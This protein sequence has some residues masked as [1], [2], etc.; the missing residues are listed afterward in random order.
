VS[1]AQTMGGSKTWWSAAVAAL[2]LLA[3]STPFAPTSTAQPSVDCTSEVWEIGSADDVAA[4]IA[5]WDAASVPGSYTITLSA[6]IEQW[7]LLEAKS[8]DYSL[9]IHGSGHQAARIRYSSAHD[10]DRADASPLTI[11]DIRLTGGLLL[12]RVRVFISDVEISG[13]AF[14]IAIDVYDSDVTLQRVLLDNNDGGIRVEGLDPPS[15]L[16]IA[17]SAVLN[18]RETPGVELRD[19]VVLIENSILQGNNGGVHSLG[20]G[21]VLVDR[22]TLIDNDNNLVAGA[23]F[24][25][26]YGVVSIVNSTIAGHDG[27]TSIGING[28]GVLGDEGRGIRIANSTVLDNDH[29]DFLGPVAAWSTVANT[30]DPTAYNDL[31]SFTEFEFFEP[32]EG[33][34]VNRSGSAGGCFDDWLAWHP[35]DDHGCLTPTP[36][37][38]VPTIALDAATAPIGVCDATLVRDPAFALFELDLETFFPDPN[39]PVMVTM[40]QQLVD[41]TGA[42]R[43]RCTVGALEATTQSAADQIQVASWDL[44]DERCCP[45]TVAGELLDALDGAAGASFPDVVFLH[46]TGQFNHPNPIG[47]CFGIV[48]PLREELAR[49]GHRMIARADWSYTEDLDALIYE[50]QIVLTRFPILAES[51]L[52]LPH[53]DGTTERD[54]FIRELVLQVNGSPLRV[55]ALNALDSDP[56]ASVGALETWIATQDAMPTIFSGGFDVET[57]TRCVAEFTARWID[58]CTPLLPANSCGPTNDEKTTSALLHRNIEGSSLSPVSANVLD[59]DSPLSGG[60][61]LIMATYSLTASDGDLDADATPTLIDNCPTTP[62]ANQIDTD[63]DGV[64]DACDPILDGDANCDGQ[65]DIIDAL[66]IAQFDAAVR[67]DSGTCPLGEA[68]TQIDAIGADANGDNLT[69]IIDALLL[70]QCS[71]GIEV[72]IC[73]VAAD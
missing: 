10:S 63:N 73:P 14:G 64:G 43:T 66:I 9:T 31:Y 20:F 1:Y 59:A 23:A 72:A 47:C 45:L 26:R 17:D 46:G 71:A 39:N 37:G 4:A 53:P 5:C 19:A 67:T 55:L 8:A 29:V 27:L 6:D 48:E 61:R 21:E 44:A 18:S 35:L 51:N 40:G 68:A 16:L 24:S 32:G 49:R 56:C 54:T 58:A 62:N 42:P 15:R 36:I 3:V 30:C 22:S 7:L 41:Q 28:G 50:G 52:R 34:P 69:D 60:H 2:L 38:C 13:N 70:A 33:P 12:D 65:R 57:S 11:T 25:S